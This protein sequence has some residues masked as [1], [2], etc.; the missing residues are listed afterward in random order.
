MAVR[1][2]PVAYCVAFVIGHASSINEFILEGCPGVTAVD[3]FKGNGE[4]LVEIEL[5]NLATHV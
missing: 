3:T 2:S 1:F 5:G 4:N